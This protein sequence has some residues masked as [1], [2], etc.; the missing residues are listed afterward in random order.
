[1]TP[2]SFY[3]LTFLVFLPLAGCLLLLPAWNSPRFAFPLALCVALL[4]LALT[5]WLYRLLAGIGGREDRFARLSAAG[6]RRPGFRP[7]ASAT[8]WGWTASRS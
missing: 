4:E 3:I 5:I 8:L 1:M 6:G 2:D 7:S